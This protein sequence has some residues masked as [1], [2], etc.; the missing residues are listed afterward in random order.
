M[1]VARAVCVSLIAN[2]LVLVSPG[3]TRSVL[4][5]SCCMAELPFGHAN[6]VALELFCECGAGHKF[7]W[8]WNVQR[9]QFAQDIRTYERTASVV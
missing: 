2:W 1:I 9:H 4:G 8:P 5:T 7:P 6:N 3:T